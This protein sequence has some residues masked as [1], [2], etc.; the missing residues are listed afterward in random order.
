MFVRR[1]AAHPSLLSL[2]LLAPASLAAATGETVKLSGPMPISQAGDVGEFALTADGERIVY[3]ADQDVEDVLEL[4]SVRTDGSSA[5]IQLSHELAQL[6]DVHSFQLDGADRVVYETA[7]AGTW[8]YSLHAVAVDGSALPMELAGPFTDLEEYRVDGGFVLFLRE[9]EGRLFSVLADGSGAPV[10]LAPAAGV[11]LFASAGSSV[12][13]KDDEEKLQVVPIDGSAAPIE[14]AEADFS[15][16]F[17]ELSDVQISVDGLYAY[18]VERRN[19]VSTGTS[20]DYD[21][22]RVPLDASQAAV[23]L[24]PAGDPESF[25][26][27]AYAHDSH[28]RVVYMVDRNTDDDLFAVDVDGSAHVQLDP[29]GVV[30]SESFRITDDG[31][32]VIFDA[33]GDLYGAP[34][35][36]SQAADPLAS[37]V[38]IEDWVLTTTDVVFVARSYVPFP[39][40]P[41]DGLY[42]V[43]IAGGEAPL[44]LN[45]PPRSNEGA[46]GAPVLRPG[47]TEVVYEED[48]LSGTGLSRELHAVPLDG[49]EPPRVVNAPLTGVGQV[50]D[51]ALTPDGE[52][53]VYQADR[54]GVFELLG[55]SVDGAG[56]AVT[57]NPLLAWS[58]TG[59]VASFHL[60]SDGES[61]LYMADQDVD[62]SLD[63]Y[64]VPPDRSSE[65]FRLTPQLPPGYIQPDF[66]VAPISNRVV[67]LHGQGADVTLYGMRTDPVE[68]PVVLDAGNLTPPIEP[69]RFTPD[70]TRIVY[71][72]GD[73]G[74]SDLFSCPSDGSAPSVRLANA[75]AGEEVLDDFLV[76]PD[77]ATVVYRATH[78]ERTWLAAV[79]SDA[80][81]QGILLNA[82]A[83]T[84][85]TVARF[86]LTPD[87]SQVL[88]VADQETSGDFEL[89][90]VPLDGSAPPVKL[91]GALPLGGDVQQIVP[92]PDGQRVLYRADQVAND[93]EELF[94]VPIDG[95]GA[96]LRLTPLVVGMSGASVA[97]DF[98][99][100]SSGEVVFYRAHQDT[101]VVELYVVPTNGEGAPVKLSGTLVPGGRVLDF[102]ITPD[103][104]RVVFRADKRF[105]DRIELFTCTTVSPPVLLH[106][107]PVSADVLTYRLDPAGKRVFYEVQ[108][109][110]GAFTG[111]Y[112]VRLDGGPPLRMSKVLPFGG[113]VD[114]DFVP[115]ADGDVVFRANQDRAETIELYRSVTVRVLGAEEPSR[116]ASVVR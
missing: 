96:P 57:Y 104:T 27:D 56:S 29:P 109:T 63:L 112:A 37:F 46:Y 105:D 62:E 39:S 102:A 21:L 89:Y 34:I 9:T 82:P 15:Q 97:G 93:Q 24:S 19:E 17:A 6:E 20:G 44:L 77:G 50:W 107:L 45:G 66:V 100:A 80:S 5:S 110:S 61:V 54:T 64:R 43:P 84:F 88:F 67:F 30:V 81:A 60:S 95:S 72:K 58:E 4:Y 2:A 51:F 78:V 22:F 25:G 16:G 32:S 70:A 55:V 18:Y 41:F 13:F 11:G 26:I 111:L 69:F 98:V 28:D 59:D 7:T 92:M 8:E 91:S 23:R 113:A 115:L 14:L 31:A 75:P 79:P 73:A 48:V 94:V 106:A 42:R 114:A 49:S 74:D 65:P 53:A 71:R 12:V 3:R 38:S 1:A 33:F 36:G 10:E 103:D 76:T 47:A 52:R 90:H 116:S 40:M 99:I 68:A 35:D 85:A 101:P 108:E 87:G 86:A 83:P